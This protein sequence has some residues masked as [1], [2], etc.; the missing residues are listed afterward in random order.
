[1]STIVKGL[2]IDKKDLHPIAEC[3]CFIDDDNDVFIVGDENIITNISSPMFTQYHAREYETIEEFL[4]I[5]YDTQLVKVL[6][7][8]NQ[9]DIEIIVK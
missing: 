8:L 5:E 4:R 3:F 7:K 9:F 6:K 2:E 1:M